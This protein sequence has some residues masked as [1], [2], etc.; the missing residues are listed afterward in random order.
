MQTSRRSTRRPPTRH[1][2]AALDVLPGAEV[3]S[4]IRPRLGIVRIS[5]VLEPTAVASDLLGGGLAH[6]PIPSAQG[7]ATPTG[8]LSVELGRVLL[9]SLVDRDGRGVRELRLRLEPAA[10]GQLAVRLERLGAPA[11]RPRLSCTELASSDLAGPQR[12]TQEIVVN[13]QATALG[14]FIAGAEVELWT[15]G[16]AAFRGL[17]RIRLCG[18]DQQQAS[19][20]TELAKRLGLVQ[21]FSPVHRTSI[22]DQLG[23]WEH[24]QGGAQEL[25]QI[26]LERRSNALV[27]PRSREFGERLRA[28]GARYACCPV[29]ARSEVLWAISHGIQSPAERW[30]D[31]RAVPGISAQF[32]PEGPELSVV[33][34]RVVLERHQGMAWS[35]PRFR[36]L[37]S[38]AVFDRLDHVGWTE[39]GSELLFGEALIG[40]MSQPE[41]HGAVMGFAYGI[42]RF[43][44]RAVCASNA[45]DCRE[46]EEVVAQSGRRDLEVLE[47]PFVQL[48]DLA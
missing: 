34:T 10:A 33:Q 6:L 46:L 12:E 7:V 42:S 30:L 22:A 43:S 23:R 47:H 40:A 48:P 5:D 9:R 41:G 20:L 2:S 27:V 21:Y 32:A 8:S 17:L 26:G 36:L 39:P 14:A 19:A 18:N 35:G 1:G 4:A 25:G 24:F 3:P 31:G 38:P 15:G 37:L 29:G 45:Q 28:L 11:R 16:P 13:L 44:V